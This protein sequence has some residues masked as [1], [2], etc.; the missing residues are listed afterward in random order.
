MTQSSSPI[1]SSCGVYF[2]I[3]FGNSHLSNNSDHIS[4]KCPAPTWWKFAVFLSSLASV[5]QDRGKEGDTSGLPLEES[6][7]QPSNDESDRS[8]R[9]FSEEESTSGES[10]HGHAEGGSEGQKRTVGLYQE[11]KV[12]DRNNNLSLRAQLMQVAMCNLC[13]IA[14]VWDCPHNTLHPCSRLYTC[15]AR[16]MADLTYIMSSPHMSTLWM[17]TMKGLPL[18]YITLR[19]MC[20]LTAPLHWGQCVLTNHTAYYLALHIILPCVLSY[21]VYVNKPLVVGE[22]ATGT[23]GRRTANPPAEAWYVE[24]D[25]RT[26]ETGIYVCT[27]ACRGRSR[28]M[29]VLVVVSTT[30]MIA[31]L[32]DARVVCTVATLLLV[33]NILHYIMVV[34]G[35][36]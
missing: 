4:C 28:G 14:S 24:E 27:C 20:M 12:D 11:E 23:G 2:G 13:G 35:Q 16:S 6:L 33:T 10:A 36:L 34:L 30:A 7:A 1:C 21:T 25:A 15:S 5:L 22:T 9:E 3:N 32:K 26:A 8:E 17:T 18:I 31:R 19:P 29:V